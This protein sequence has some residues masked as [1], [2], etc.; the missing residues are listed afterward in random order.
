MAR[1]IRMGWV[2]CAVLAGTLPL[3]AQ[4]LAPNP[5]PT[6][7]LTGPKP[8][9]AESGCDSIVGGPIN[10]GVTWTQVWQALNE[11]ASCTQ[12]CHLGTQPVAELD[13]SNRNLAVYFLVNQQ[14]VQDSLLRVDPGNPAGSLLYQKVSC[15]KPRA[16][17][18]MPP[19][20]GHVQLEIQALI[21]DWIEQGAYGEGVEDPIAREF[22]F[23]NSMESVRR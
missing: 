6:L 12:N 14:S 19:P 5:L 3:A 2:V 11:G 4:S 9:L 7:A 21:Y 20:F 23:R 18:P 8:D 15:D 1:M 22:V 13:F 17:Q 16:G 10:I